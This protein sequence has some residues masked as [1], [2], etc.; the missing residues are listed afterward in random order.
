MIS[1]I[2]SSSNIVSNDIPVS[3]KQYIAE[4]FDFLISTHPRLRISA[5]DCEGSDFFE[6]EQ[7]NVMVDREPVNFFRDKFD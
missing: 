2:L 4:V 5:L 7:Y 3:C 6:L 1:T